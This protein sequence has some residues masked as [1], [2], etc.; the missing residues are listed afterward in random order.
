MSI[1]VVG[2]KM[3]LE[4]QKLFGC[5]EWAHRFAAWSDN[6]LANPLDNLRIPQRFL[7]R[8]RCYIKVARSLANGYKWLWA[9][10]I[11]AMEPVVVRLVGSDTLMHISKWVRECIIHIPG[12]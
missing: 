10:M 5:D 4:A 11:D 7:D 12:K 9:M 1:G 8:M 6:D 3:L 2:A